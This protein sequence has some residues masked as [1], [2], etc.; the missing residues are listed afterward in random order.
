MPNRHFALRL[1]AVAIVFVCVATPLAHATNVTVIYKT[2]RT[3]TGE[4]IQQ[5]ADSIVVRIAGIDTPISR[6]VIREMRVERPVEEVYRQRAARLAPNDIAERMELAKWVFNKR[7]YKLCVEACADILRVRPNHSDAKTLQD[8][9]NAWLAH[10]AKVA[11]DKAARQ[12]HSSESPPPRPKRTRTDRLTDKDINWIRLLEYDFV[13]RQKPRVEVP[14][15]VVN[16]LFA[17]HGDNPLVPKGL[18][19]RRSLLRKQGFEKLD[20]LFKVQDRDLWGRAVVRGDPV[21]LRTFRIRFNRTY[22]VNYCGSAG[23]HG[24]TGGAGGLALL[25]DDIN[26]DATVY[27]NFYLLNTAE[28]KNGYLIDRSSPHRSLLLQY[29]LP[30]VLAASPHPKVAGW[31]ANPAL[32]R[33]DRSP[34]YQGLVDWISR[35]LYAPMPR[36]HDVIRYKSPAKSAS[37][38]PPP[39]GD[40]PAAGSDDGPRRPDPATDPPTDD[41]APARPEPPPAPG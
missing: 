16:E 8:A 22:V 24:Q 7:A 36:Y 37:P 1:A 19:A 6:D 28:S 2:G 25:R 32:Q 40:E 14:V 29:G 27:T 15:D 31:S 23:C 35:D 20:L 38:P 17:K 4:L 12:G 21:G 13:D 30:R 5:K 33:G 39:D 26:G 18:A 34:T 3:I 11:K 10:E 41:A 9:A